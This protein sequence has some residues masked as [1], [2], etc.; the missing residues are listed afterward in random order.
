MLF[1]GQGD[2]VITSNSTAVYVNSISYGL[3]MVAN[4]AVNVGYIGLTRAGTTTLTANVVGL[5]EITISSNTTALYVDH[6]DVARSNNTSTASPA[7]GGTFTAIDSITTNARGH[8]TAINTK[9]VTLPVDP[10][11]TYTGANG[12]AL[13]GTQFYAAVGA[14][15][16]SNSTGIHMPAVATAGTSSSGISAIT[17]DAQGRVTSVTGSAGY[18][19]SSGVTSVATGN[20]LTG[21]TI[22]TTGTVSV[23]ANNGIV[24]N[25]TGVFVNAGNA[26][27]ANS[28][29]VHHQDTSSQASVNNSGQ[30]FI[31]DI[32]L[33]TYGHITAITSATATGSVTAYAAAKFYAVYN[34]GSTYVPGTFTGYT[35][36]LKNV[37]SVTINTFG[38]YTFNFTSAFA[39]ADYKV[40]AT[41]GM[42]TNTATVATMG[43]VEQAAGSVRVMARYTGNSSGGQFSLDPATY[44]HLIALEF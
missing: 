39:D 22:T 13:S 11:T 8:V 21:G 43:I 41:S 5:D 35:A 36:G 15:L 37:S 44:T 29:G 23:I 27:V 9:T 20:G 3:S 17:I 16:V 28:S 32:T 7:S 14:T 24:A 6:A 18:V 10:N 19:T 12:V 1:V 30:S 38:N 31:Q 26:I 40:V 4:D 25:S 42:A 2:V 34:P 33:D